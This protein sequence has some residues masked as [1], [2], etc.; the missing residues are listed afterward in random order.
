M[1]GFGPACILVVH[2][3]AVGASARVVDEVGITFGVNK[4][5][6]PDSNE[7][8]HQNPQDQFQPCQAHGCSLSELVTSLWGPHDDGAWPNTSSSAPE[9]QL[10][11]P[12]EQLANGVTFTGPRPEP[13]S[14]RHRES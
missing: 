1:A 14:L 2:G 12:A 8:A 6:A 3:M 5:V 9:E 11:F 4:R 13:S 7:R 10:S